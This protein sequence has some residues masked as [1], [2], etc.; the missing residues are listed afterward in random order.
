MILTPYKI[1]SNRYSLRYH[2]VSDSFHDY[3]LQIQETPLHAF[4]SMGKGVSRIVPRARYTW[5]VRVIPKRMIFYKIDL[6]LCIALL[7][8]YKVK[9]KTIHRHLYNEYE[10]DPVIQLVFTV[11]RVFLTSSFILFW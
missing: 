4:I 2:D 6:S 9:L 8:L 7:V 11:A 10:S 5:L 3:L 1:V